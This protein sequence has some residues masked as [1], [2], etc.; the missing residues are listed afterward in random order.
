MKIFSPRPLKGVPSHSRVWAITSSRCPSCVPARQGDFRRKKACKETKLYHVLV[1]LN[2]NRIT[3]HKWTLSSQIRFPTGFSTSPKV[4]GRRS[5]H[6]G[7]LVCENCL[8]ASTSPCCD[9]PCCRLSL[10]SL[11]T[12]SSLLQTQSTVLCSPRSPS[13]WGGF[14]APEGAVS[15]YE[16]RTALRLLFGECTLVLTSKVHCV[17]H[18]VDRK[19]ISIR[20]FD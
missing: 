4:S 19:V 1:A 5:M 15:E 11:V 20:W 8:S 6:N 12:A 17:N 2:S 9:F 13:S 10:S 18:G 16:K 14:Y 3:L 7:H